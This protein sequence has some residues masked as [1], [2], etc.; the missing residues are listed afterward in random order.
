MR[1]ISCH[2]DG[3]GKLSDLDLEF[4]NGIFQ[5]EEENGWGKSTLAV[6][7]KVMLY[8]FD[9]TRGN[10]ITN[11]KKRYEPWGKE[12]NYG[13]RLIFSV[14]TKEYILERNFSTARNKRDYFAIYDR[15]TNLPSSDFSEKLGEELFGISS[16]AFQNTIYIG[17]TDRSVFVTSDIQAKIGG[18]KEASEDL[19]NFEKKDRVLHDLLNAL[20]PNRKT[21]TLYKLSEEIA[22]LYGIEAETKEKE[23]ELSEKGNALYLLRKEKEEKEEKAKEIQRMWREAVNDKENRMLR[24][25]KKRLEDRICAI[26]HAIKEKQ[27]AFV[28]E[29]SDRRMLA[30]KLEAIEEAIRFR[31]LREFYEERVE[32]EDTSFKIPAWEAKEEDFIFLKKRIAELKLTL[33]QRREIG[34]SF[35]ENNLYSNLLE[36]FS[37]QVPAVEEFVEAEKKHLQRIEYKRSLSSYK[38]RMDFEREEERKRKL[39]KYFC[40]IFGIGLLLGGGLLLPF[41]YFF[42]MGIG[43]IGIGF[44]LGAFLYRGKKEMQRI[45][46]EIKKVESDIFGLENELMK[47]FLQFQETYQE[48]TALSKLFK[49]KENLGL[50]HRLKKRKEEEE[51]I[52]RKEN[53]LKIEINRLFCGF[54]IPSLTKEEDLKERKKQLLFLR[55]MEIDINGLKGELLALKREEEIFVNAHKEVD[56]SLSYVDRTL[57]LEELKESYDRIFQELELDKEKIRKLESE[58][59]EMEIVFEELGE[60]LLEK[61][62]KERERDKLLRKYKLLKKTKEYLNEA[63][64]RFLSKHRNPVKE[65]FEQYY[66]AIASDDKIYEMDANLNLQVKEGGRRRELALLSRGYQ[67]LVSFCRRLAMA[68]AMYPE[69]KPFFIM[70]DPF[71]NLDEEK[72][73]KGRNLLS[74]LA[75]DYQVLY[76]YCHASRKI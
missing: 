66:Y 2:I 29:F 68:L 65:K 35:D 51:A 34:L 31:D 36:R 72:L 32:V 62:E 52:R 75:K 25:E 53:G 1:L 3:F 73:E 28:G 22:G 55:Q 42:G 56:F 7:L 14:G 74:E 48:G 44:L 64:E 27:S 58:I 8:G 6:F 43:T 17:Q 16:E 38:E 10:E 40:I 37:D 41:Q 4:E 63:K 15:Q 46:E 60:R 20:S 71:V 5:M 21:G 12:K 49:I 13:G 57:S 45:M 69:E 59:L 50:Y 11:E 67:D 30:L 70:D 26:S 54:G 76:F 47:F 33:E 61:K 18:R 9:T 19:E 23:I 24:K 39:R